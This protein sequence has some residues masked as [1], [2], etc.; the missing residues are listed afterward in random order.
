V[1]RVRSYHIPD[2]LAAERFL[3]RDCRAADIGS[4]G[5]LPG[6]PLAIARPDCRMYLVESVGKKAEFLAAALDRLRLVNTRVIHS[7]AE[8]IPPLAC[9]VVL[10]RLTGP[11]R[12]TLPRL[13]DHCHP[14]GS[15]VLFKNPTAAE[16]LPAGLLRRLALAVADTVDL[17]LAPGGIPRRFI[18]LRPR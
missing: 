1:E 10:S 6:I 18:L 5:G 13:A 7:R 8:E 4:G 12:T 3:P 14:D 17:R 15:I 16:P 11:L 2:S 9:D